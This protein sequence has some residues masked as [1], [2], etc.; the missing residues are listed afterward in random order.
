MD[1]QSVAIGLLILSLAAVSVASWLLNRAHERERAQWHEERRWLCKC[2]II[3][4]GGRVPID[5]SVLDAQ[6]ALAQP[7]PPRSH[8]ISIE[9][10]REEE[11]GV[12]AA[13]NRSQY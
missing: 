12:L 13:M 2:A 7:I 8:G 3:S 10:P 5:Q 6:R 4:N 11:D 9:V 1:T